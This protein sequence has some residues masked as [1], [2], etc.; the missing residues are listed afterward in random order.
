MPFNV[1]TAIAETRVASLENSWQKV[2]NVREGSTALNLLK[3]DD[4]RDKANR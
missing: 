1:L 3:L 2:Q 4:R